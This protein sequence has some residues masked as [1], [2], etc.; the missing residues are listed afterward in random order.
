MEELTILE[1]T[2]C[3]CGFVICPIIMSLVVKDIIKDFKNMKD[4]EESMFGEIKDPEETKNI[5]DI[6]N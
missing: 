3:L 2:I 5:N 1:K 4:F 6:P